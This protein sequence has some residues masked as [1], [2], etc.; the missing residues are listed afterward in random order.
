MGEAVA[1]LARRCT[2]WTVFVLFFI[3]GSILFFVGE[4]WMAPFRFAD[5]RSW[6]L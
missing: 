5:G 2:W 3:P 6:D 1:K 4:I